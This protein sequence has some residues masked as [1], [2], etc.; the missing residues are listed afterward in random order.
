M[1]VEQPP[2]EVLVA[3]VI[4]AVLDDDDDDDGEA[5][6]EGLEL[7]GDSCGVMVGSRESSLEL[8]LLLLSEL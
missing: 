7:G 8:L 5:T 3:V 6:R 1:F 4:D 2:R